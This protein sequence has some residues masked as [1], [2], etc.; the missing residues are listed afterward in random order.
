MFSTAAL[1][2]PKT[3]DFF[4]KIKITILELYGLCECSG[5]HTASMKGHGKNQYRNG[6]CGKG[7]NGTKTKIINK[8]QYDESKL[9]Q[10]KSNYAIGEASLL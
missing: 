8:D 10:I 4:E 9:L 2:R 3:T 1:L 6:S 5:P 7:I